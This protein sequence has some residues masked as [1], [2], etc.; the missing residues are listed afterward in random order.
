MITK[1]FEQNIDKQ[2]FLGWNVL[3]NDQELTQ[4]NM[5]FFVNGYIKWSDEFII[6]DFLFFP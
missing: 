3:S 2:L 6:K 5:Y 4:F 1:G